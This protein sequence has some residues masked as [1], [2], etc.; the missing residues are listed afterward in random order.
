[1]VITLD[2]RNYFTRNHKD[3]EGWIGYEVSLDSYSQSLVGLL[4][5]KKGDL[6]L[7]DGC[8]NGRFS[9]AIAKKGA[10][11]VALDINKSILRVATN[12]AKQEKSNNCLDPVQGDIQNL[13]FRES[14]FDKLLCAHNLW[15]IPNYQVAVSEMARTLKTGGKVVADHLN[16]LNWRILLAYSLYLM[17]KTLRKSPTPVFFRTPKEILQPFETFITRIFSLSVSNEPIVDVKSKAW[18][19]RLIISG[20]KKKV[21]GTHHI[22]IKKR[23]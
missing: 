23:I 9:V 13:P 19:P 14:V 1:M 4:D 22:F 20:S 21:Q 17:R 5:L 18:T 12:L 11:V 3:L 2:P 6:V 15:Y 10:R 7:D 8:G 16:I